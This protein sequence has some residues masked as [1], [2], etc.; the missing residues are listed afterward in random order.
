MNLLSSQ[1]REKDSAIPM[2][3]TRLVNSVG[4]LSATWY[5][6]PSDTWLIMDYLAFAPVKFQETLGPTLILKQNLQGLISP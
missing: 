6:K 5:F 3:D 2:L 1:E 4:N